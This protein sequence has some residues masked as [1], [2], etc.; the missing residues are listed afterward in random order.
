MKLVPLLVTAFISILKKL[1]QIGKY[2]HIGLYFVQDHVYD[3]E[4][5]TLLIKIKS[6]HLKE[7]IFINGLMYL[8]YSKFFKSV[9]SIDIQL[10]SNF[11]WISL[12]VAQ[13]QL[14]QLKL[15]CCTYVSFVL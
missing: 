11:K 1:W 5:K 6:G 13:Q 4:T 7:S 14:D 2:V 12:Q 15:R 8:L 3:V 9:G 10:I